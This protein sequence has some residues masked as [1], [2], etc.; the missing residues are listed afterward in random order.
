MSAQIVA[1][2][3]AVVAEIN[4]TALLTPFTAAA[5]RSYAPSNATEDLKTLEVTVV[6]AEWDPAPL[7]RGETDNQYVIHIGIQKRIGPM[8]MTNDAINTACDPLMQLVQD[9]VDLFQRE[10]LDV[11]GIAAEMVT[12]NRPIYS[13]DHIREHRVFT[14]IIQLTFKQ[15]RNIG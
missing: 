2:A 6:A 10:N 8:A 4:G 14:S 13:P 11:N 7:S 3:D 9:I 12:T 5:V 1:I 15:T